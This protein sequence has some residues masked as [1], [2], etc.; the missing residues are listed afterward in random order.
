MNWEK[1]AQIAA[2]LIIVAVAATALWAST[3]NN[4]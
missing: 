1:I 3:H 4:K 2:L